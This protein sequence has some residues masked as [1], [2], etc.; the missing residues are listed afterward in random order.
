MWLSRCECASAPARGELWG[1][2]D[3]GGRDY[4]DGAC[5]LMDNPTRAAWLGEGEG[6]DSPWSRV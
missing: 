6:P 2:G 4:Q 1:A 3:A 5:F